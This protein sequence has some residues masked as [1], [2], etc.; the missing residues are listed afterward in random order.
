M[1]QKSAAKKGKVSAREVLWLVLLSTQLTHCLHIYHHRNQISCMR[2][3]Q[4]C[5]T[6][7]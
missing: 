7:R 6:L 4:I 3:K 2:M 1:E 5:S